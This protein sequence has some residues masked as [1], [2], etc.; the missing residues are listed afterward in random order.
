MLIPLAL[1]A[2]LLASACGEGGQPAAGKIA[3]GSCLREDPDDPERATSCSL[4]LI[5][6]DGSN[7]TPLTSEP[8]RLDARP[9]WSPDGTRIAFTACRLP[10]SSDIAGMDCE[11]RTIAPDGTGEAVLPR[12]DTPPGDLLPDWS[13]DGRRLA[14]GSCRPGADGDKEPDCGLWVMNADGSGRREVAGRHE[15][16]VWSP[17]SRRIAFT[18]H[19]DEKWNIYVVN[20][21]GSGLANLTNN[22]RDINYEDLAWSPDGKRIA[23][24]ANDEQWDLYVMTPDGTGLTNLTN[25]Q[26]KQHQFYNTPS[27]S[28]DGK[29]IAFTSGSLGVQDVYVMN[30]DGSGITNITGAPSGGYDAEEPAWSPDGSRLLFTSDRDG[31][32]DVYSIN[33][34]GSGLLRLTQD[35][36]ADSWP[37]WS[38]LAR[39]GR[40][41]APA[42]TDTAPAGPPALG[43]LAFLSDRDNPRKGSDIYLVA[44]DGSGLR[45]LTTQGAEGSASWSPDGKRIAVIRVLDTVGGVQ[46][47]D[48]FLINADGSGETNLTNAPGVERTPAWS[49]D[50]SRIAFMSMRSGREEIYVINVDGSGQAN[51]TN[52]RLFVSHSSEPVWSPDG[53]RITF[54]AQQPDGPYGYDIYAMNV[55]GSGL[56]N[57]T[58]EPSGYLGAFAWSPDGSMIAFASG[59]VADIY[60]V[61]PDGSGRTNLTNSQGGEGHPAWSPDGNQIAFSSEGEIYVMNADGSGRTRLTRSGYSDHFPAWSPD[62]RHI[63]FV[64]SRGQ[65]AEVFVVGTD[66]SGLTN[67]SNNPASDIG[68]AWSPVP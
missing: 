29:R 32:R 4:Y 57:V 52:S 21:D 6:A 62:G 48:V 1:V 12:S 54:I 26:P 64:S 22:S 19:R 14:F 7:L 8:G 68:P 43:T 24:V 11:I 9:V 35:P 44:G 23:F 3:F 18:A 39:P 38:P 41:A 30:A 51:L 53:A 34:D 28:P 55:D 17:D 27:W 40:L 36:A 25:S 58:S 59:G 31:N 46:N 56:T 50:G 65:D 67:L 20:A 5:D 2:L 49:P 13:P 42:P 47:W 15:H 37:A 33:A 45:R 66:G 61:N 16:R 63:T 10:D 60:V